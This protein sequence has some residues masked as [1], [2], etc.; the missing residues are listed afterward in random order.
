M[1]KFQSWREF[2]STVISDRDEQFRLAQELNVTPLTLTRWVQ[3]ASTPQTQQLQSLLHALP[4]YQRTLHPLIAKEFEQMDLTVPE[5][6]NQ[7]IDIPSVFYA[8]VL[9]GSTALSH[10]ILFWSLANMVIQQALGQLDP[11]AWA[12]SLKSFAVCLHQAVA[13]FSAC[14]SRLGLAPLPVAAWSIRLSS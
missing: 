5:L 4:R 13:K 7:V 9:S 12:W 3:G 6:T 14:A 11:C 8:H 1:Q 2:L 10:P